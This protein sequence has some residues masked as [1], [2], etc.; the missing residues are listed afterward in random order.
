MKGQGMLRATRPERT[1]ARTAEVRGYRVLPRG[2]RHASIPAR[3]TPARA[4]SSCG[5]TCPIGRRCPLGSTGRPVA[6]PHHDPAGRGDRRD[7][8][9]RDGRPGRPADRQLRRSRST[10]ANARAA[11][12]RAGPSSRRSTTPASSSR[13]GCGR[14]WCSNA[15]SA[16]AR[17]TPSLAA[18][19]GAPGRLTLAYHLDYGRGCA[20]PRPELLRGAVARVVPRSSWR[21]AARSCWSPKPTA[22]RAAGIGARTT[23]ADLLI[24]GRDG[25]HRQRPALSRRVRAAQDPRHGRRP[26]SSGLRPPRVRRRP[27]LGTPDQPCPG[28]PAARAGRPS[29]PRSRR[30]PMP[31]G[32]NGMLDI[33]GIMNLLPHRYP[34]LLVDRVLELEPGHAGGGH[35][36]RERQRAVLSRATGRGCR[37]C[38]AC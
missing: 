27:P 20:D 30:A 24:F 37:S 2:R 9:A 26:G 12:A 28:A 33:Q 36:E 16:C 25:C 8:R 19:P 1:L 14:P 10:P 11:T 5:P 31:L 35:Q 13:T 6:A 4:S 32:Q 3:P 21:P 29:R 15:R 22:L 18:I 38:R 23:A 34:F 17:E 7:D